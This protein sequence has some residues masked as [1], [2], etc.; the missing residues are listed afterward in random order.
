MPTTLIL[1]SI[2]I[3]ALAIAGMAVGVI[4][5]HRRLK[6]TCGGLAGRQDG[7]GN[8]VCEMCVDPSPE[9]AG[10]PGSSPSMAEE[11]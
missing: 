10:T 9:C 6:G 3:F 5:S 1:L 2:G 8:A 4:L 11:G 7:E